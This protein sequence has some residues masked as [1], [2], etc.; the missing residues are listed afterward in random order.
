MSVYLSSSYEI[1]CRVCH[2]FLGNDLS[3]DSN[4]ICQQCEEDKL[5]PK[6]ELIPTEELNQSIETIE[7]IK[8][9]YKCLSQ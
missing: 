2:A 4:A 1:Y 7:R 8:E 5:L 6:L 3:Q 9:E